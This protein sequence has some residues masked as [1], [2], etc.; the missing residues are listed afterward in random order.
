MSTELAAEKLL[1]DGGYF[2]AIEV[3]R[4]FGQSTQHG[5]R[6]I[7]N[8][9]ANPRF[10]IKQRFKPVHK[11]KVLSIDGRKQSIDK[12]QNGAPLFARP[13]SLSGGV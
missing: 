2:T 1:D 7:D 5:Q 10:K 12:L 13:K 4:L 11:I 6:Y 9:L 3:A 8:L